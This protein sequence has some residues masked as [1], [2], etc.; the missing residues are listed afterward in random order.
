M[1]ELELVTYEGVEVELELEPPSSSP[2][3][4]VVEVAVLPGP[5]EANGSASLLRTACQKAASSGVH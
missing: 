4:V 1:S 5:Y 2:P 3:A